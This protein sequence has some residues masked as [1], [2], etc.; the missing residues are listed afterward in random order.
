[1]VLLLL[2]RNGGGTTVAGW[3]VTV[4]TAVTIGI[5]LRRRVSTD[6]QCIELRCE[7]CE[8]ILPFQFMPKPL[9]VI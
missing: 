5:L 3:S 9:I 2:K 6:L 1:M 8:L 4:V 7:I